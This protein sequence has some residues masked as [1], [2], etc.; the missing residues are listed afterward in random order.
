M[1][2]NSI[3]KWDG[4]VWT[5]LGSG[6]NDGVWRMASIGTDLYAGGIFTTAGNLSANHIAK[7]SCTL[8]TGIN[9]LNMNQQNQLNQNQ[10][11]PFNST[12]LIKYYVPKTGS[13]KLSVYDIFGKEIKTLVNGVRGAGSYENSFDGSQLT[14]GVYFYTL[15]IEGSTQSRKMI[16]MK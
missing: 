2:A 7:Y 6:M 11:N 9:E 3:A 8:P 4:T 5:P 1:S 10:P 12:T 15:T 16:L 14:S 13:V